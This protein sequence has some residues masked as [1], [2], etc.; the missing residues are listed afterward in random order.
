MSRPLHAPEPLFLALFPYGARPDIGLADSSAD[1]LSLG[2]ARVL[3]A[4]QARREEYLLDAVGQYWQLLS[5]VDAGDCRLLG[6][7]PA[8]QLPASAPQA[9]IAMLRMVWEHRLPARLQWLEWLGGG[10]LDDDPLPIRM[11]HTSS[12]LVRRLREEGHTV[13]QVRGPMGTDE[14][15]LLFKS[16][17]A[18]MPPHSAFGGLL[19]GS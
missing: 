15:V 1:R 11:A 9:G 12:C 14:H 18:T 19:Q 6:R 13:K 4:G 8:S 3:D 2:A 5:C 10:L 7:V 17:R 16:A